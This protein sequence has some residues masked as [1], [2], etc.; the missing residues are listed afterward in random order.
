[1]K[2]TSVNPWLVRAEGTFWGEYFFVEVTTDEG[3]TGW[4]EITTTTRLANRAV[5]GMIRQLNEL[6]VGDDPSEIERIW[7]KI[8]RA[9]TY[10]GSRGATCH[11]ISGI[12]IAL[13]DIQGKA[14]EQPIYKLLGGA[15]RD[16]IP[17]YCH[18]DQR[19]FTS[20]EGIASEIPVLR[21]KL[22]NLL[23]QAPGNCHV[24]KEASKSLAKWFRMK[25]RLSRIESGLLKRIIAGMLENHPPRQTA[26][27]EQRA[28]GEAEGFILSGSEGQY[29]S[30]VL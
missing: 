1:M 30:S 14:L 17:L 21:I 22:R 28:P 8:F 27:T 26:S 4:G 29:E 23:K 13:W 11:A 3:I 2:I 15:V 12:D 10:M 16:S 20:Q 5:A 7:H 19:K 18:P 9:F 25:Y 6:I 24:L